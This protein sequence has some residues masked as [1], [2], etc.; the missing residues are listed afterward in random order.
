MRYPSGRIAPEPGGVGRPTTEGETLRTPALILLL[1][2][3]AV[4]EA[5]SSQMCPSPRIALILHDATGRVTSEQAFDSVTFGRGA[6]RNPEPRI[7]R[8]P[9]PGPPHASRSR[10]SIPA[11]VWQARTCIVEFPSITLWKSDRRMELV[12]A[13]WLQ[14]IGGG[15]PRTDDAIV[16]ELPP[17]RSG[18]WMLIPCATRLA[19]FP[20]VFVGQER[21]RRLRGRH[22]GRHAPCPAGTI[23]VSLRDGTVVPP[24]EPRE[25][26]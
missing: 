6:P 11:L 15:S 1:T 24:R 19:Q 16:L 12:A 7:D 5:A 2:S 14:T 3:L 26:G 17:F 13:L 23:P 22:P 20:W 25:G 18:R 4:P 8:Y 9:V 10:D 21:W